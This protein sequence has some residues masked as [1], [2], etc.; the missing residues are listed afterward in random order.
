[1]NAIMHPSLA[2]QIETVLLTGDLSKLTPE[3]RMQY[4]KQVC[5]SLGLNPLTKP[6]EYITLN[7]KMVLYAKRDATEQLRKIHKVSITSLTVSQVQD[8]Y[9]VTALAQDG[10]GR[11]DSSTGAVPLGNSKGEELANKLMKAETKAKRRVTLSICGLGMLDETEV[12]SIDVAPKPELLPAQRRSSVPASTLPEA[13]KDFTPVEEVSLPQIAKQ[14]NAGTHPDQQPA[15]VDQ[16]LIS[17]AQRKRLFA[18]WKK[19][20]WEDSEVK[21]LLK[22]DYGITSTT[23]IPKAMYEKICKRIEEGPLAKNEPELDP[24]QDAN[25][26][27]A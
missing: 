23:M 11:T 3:Q 24:F 6:F 4:F 15:K 27:I 20:D 12:G 2:E 7:G 10:T 19:A 14:L 25:E 5:E 9:V 8:V 22:Q 21:D 17:E 13:V 16:K 18:I 26:D 1:M